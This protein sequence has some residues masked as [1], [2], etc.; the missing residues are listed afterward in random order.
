M[1]LL[2]H[3]LMG[4]IYGDIPVKSCTIEGI[5]KQSKLKKIISPYN[6]ILDNEP[7]NALNSQLHPFPKKNKNKNG[8]ILVTL[9]KFMHS[10]EPM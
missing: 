1:K 4:G 9:W 2:L 5:Y 7:A 10:V 6:P 3:F 8:M